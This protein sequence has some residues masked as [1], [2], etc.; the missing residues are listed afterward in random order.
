VGTSTRRQGLGRRYGVWNNQRVE[1]GGNKIW[2][3][4][5]KLIKKIKANAVSKYNIVKSNKIKLDLTI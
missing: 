4:K 5:Y 1:W 3:V 2:S